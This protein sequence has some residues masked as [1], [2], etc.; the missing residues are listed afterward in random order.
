MVDWVRVERANQP[1]PPASLKMERPTV[2]SRTL[3][4]STRGANA[5]DDPYL[6]PC[7]SREAAA[8]A[9]APLRRADFRKP[10]ED[11]VSTTATR[12]TTVT[13]NGSTSRSASVPYA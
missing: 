6:G 8:I 7:L 4:D 10:K 3:R 1:C 13:S 5:A 2:P 12:T 11:R 9:D